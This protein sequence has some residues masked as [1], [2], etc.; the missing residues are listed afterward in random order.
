MD[1]QSIGS[2]GVATTFITLLLL[3]RY[4][5]SN[6]CRALRR[7][8]NYLP[9][10]PAAHHC[11]L[12]T[13]CAALHATAPRAARITRFACFA[14][15]RARCCVRCRA[16][17]AFSIT[18]AS[19]ASSAATAR[20]LPTACKQCAARALPTLRA[21][22]LFGALARV[23]SYV[24]VMSYVYLPSWLDMAAGD[25]GDAATLAAAWRTAPGRRRRHQHLRVWRAAVNV[26][27]WPTE[28]PFFSM[29]DA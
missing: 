10:A 19:R 13:R 20:A 22:A 2:V 7:C 14:L 6:M 17:A 11:V 3:P 12:L 1:S 4:A 9:P 5:R 23:A 25:S 21:G 15:M 18:A 29:V 16:G 26:A 8:F 24:R 27:W 28:P